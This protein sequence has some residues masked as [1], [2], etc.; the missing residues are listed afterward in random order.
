MR[1]KKIDKIIE[2]SV[3]IHNIQACTDQLENNT[4]IDDTIDKCDSLVKIPKKRG[5]KPKGGKIIKQNV[6]MNTNDEIKQNVILHLKCS[7]S[8]VTENVFSLG[9]TYDP[10]IVGNVDGYSFESKDLTFD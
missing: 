2:N 8:D 7:L 10:N 4:D 3:V 9:V 6:N 1:T 5:R